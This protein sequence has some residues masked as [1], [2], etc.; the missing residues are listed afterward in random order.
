MKPILKSTFLTLSL[1]ATT[2]ANC[3]PDKADFF[4]L[5]DDLTANL[6]S[7][8]NPLEFARINQ[9]YKGSRSALKNKMARALSPFGIKLKTG[10]YK[11][12]HELSPKKPWSIDEINAIYC[13]EKIISSDRSEWEKIEDLENFYLSFIHYSKNL[14]N[15]RNVDDPADRIASVLAEYNLI[16][17]LSHSILY[18]ASLLLAAKT[19]PEAD[20]KL[21]FKKSTEHFQD[22]KRIIGP[23]PYSRMSP[24]IWTKL[25][26]ISHDDPRDFSDQQ[27]GNRLERQIDSELSKILRDNRGLLI[28]TF[29]SHGY[30]SSVS[31]LESYDYRL[32]ITYALCMNEIW[33]IYV[34][35]SQD[36]FS[37]KSSIADILRNQLSSEQLE[38]I[39]DESYYLSLAEDQVGASRM[40]FLSQLLGP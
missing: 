25:R 18:D 34:R 10:T 19:H 1:L 33:G 35:H 27:L 7:F 12:W 6:I 4:T 40:R 31:Y 28:G 5:P 38:E 13:L 8:L 29:L 17:H 3:T 9:V 23:S 26:V 39:M 32:P 2:S 14:F 24:D 16:N 36:Y 21:R 15:V 37:L 22:L 30:M 20:Y 11:F